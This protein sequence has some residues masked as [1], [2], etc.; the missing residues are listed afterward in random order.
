MLM[1]FNHHVLGYR[2]VRSISGAMVDPLYCGRSDL[3]YPQVHGMLI[4]LSVNVVVLITRCIMNNSKMDISYHVVSSKEKE[5]TKRERRK[6]FWF[7]SYH[8]QFV[9]GRKRGRGRGRVA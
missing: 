6:R 5:K 2:H 3:K 8:R 4:V 9:R 1:R 7:I